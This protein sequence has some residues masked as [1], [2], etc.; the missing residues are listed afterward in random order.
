M[1]TAALGFFGAPSFFV[2][3]EIFWGND[4]LE[5]AFAFAA[6]GQARP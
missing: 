5:E 2:S 3:D 4:R 1:P 6:R